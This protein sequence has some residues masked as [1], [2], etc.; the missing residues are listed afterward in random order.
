[1]VSAGAEA[2]DASAGTVVVVV[3]SLENPM[4][5]SPSAY[6][7]MAIPARGMARDRATTLI[8]NRLTMAPTLVRNIVDTHWCMTAKKSL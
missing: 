4:G 3:V 8:L 6:A 7:G 2:C 1:V 5:A